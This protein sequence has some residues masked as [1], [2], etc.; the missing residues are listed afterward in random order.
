MSLRLRLAIS[1]GLVTA[2]SLGLLGF[3]VVQ[4]TRSDLIASTR[5]QLQ[6]SLMNR[7][8]ATPPPAN[9]PANPDPREL[10]TAHLII[11]PDGST[12][13]AEPAG[14]PT[15][16]TPLPEL[17]PAD[18]TA[19]RSGRS[20]TVR[21]TA[22]G[23][24]Y[25]A[26]ATPGKDRDLEVEAAPLAEVD[27]TIRSLTKRFLIG[28]LLTLLL[29]V[30][31]VVAALRNGL[32]P[33]DDVIATANAVA[34]GEREQRIP[35]DQGP[36]E[37]RQLSSAL[38]T[39]L[40]RQR[41]GDAH[42]RRF[43][44]DASHELQ[45]PITSVIGWTEL[46]RKGALDATGQTTAT[47]RIDSEARRMS[48][49]VEDLAVL[50]RLDERRSAQWCEVDLSAVAHNAIVD[51]RAVDPARTV[52]LDAPDPTM[53][54][55]DPNQLRQVIDNLLRNVRVHTPVGTVAHVSIHSELRHVIVVVEDEGPGI[56]PEHLGHVFDR[57]WRQDASRTRSTGGSGLGLAIVS[58]IVDS[59]C[60]FIIAANRPDGG[61]RFT[62]QLPAQS[63]QLH[64]H[65]IG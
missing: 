6:R 63:P 36:T 10:V 17:S 37:I 26:F 8:K 34:G 30:A 55:G 61:A 64:A 50:A 1:I 42:L 45:T 65:P 25:L 18:I 57:F 31:A 54:Q 3:A 44:A 23:P 4:S 56:D 20:V 60:G 32:R 38:D 47:A 40:Q 27:A 28:A 11:D 19:L 24:R 51:A 48:V 52:T 14:P 43:V 53:V 41:A 39:M 33:L 58:A 2:L 59:H 15:D 12:R 35:T 29:A 21:S 46:L 9:R 62:V 5:Q 49:L 16:P 13:V 22:G 7:V